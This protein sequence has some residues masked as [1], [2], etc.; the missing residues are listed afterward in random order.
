MSKVLKQLNHIGLSFALSI[1]VAT[2][3]HA[4]WFSDTIKWLKSDKAS[5]VASQV[6]LDD[7]PEQLLS[8]Q[9]ISAAFKQALDLSSK[10]VIQQVSEIN[11][12]NQDPK[13]KIPLP[14]EYRKATDIM[15]KV[16]FGSL[17]DDMELKINRAAESAAPEAL[18]LFKQAI[19]DMTFSDV[20]S[21]YEGENDA[22]TQY[23][24]Q[25]MGDQLKDKMRPIVD[26]S[27]SEVGAI[28]TYDKFVA[29]YQ[30]IP[31]VPDLGG[32][33]TEHTLNKSLDGIFLY[34]A[35]Q[36]QSIRQD[37][38]KRST[39]LLKKVFSQ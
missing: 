6:G 34:L 14:K 28:A 23:F 31:F 20:K 15:K 29:N 21:I 16:G 33:I 5:E 30:D 3:A 22:A 32:N 35:E 26:K 8:N 24:R 11:G 9:D 38:V 39:E 12:F 2:P 27:L 10:A 36:E 13:I 19:K 1:A 18:S 37:P 4:G 17:V 7:V 25:T